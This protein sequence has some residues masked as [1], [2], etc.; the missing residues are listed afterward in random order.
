V[1]EQL[2]TAHTFDPTAS[3]RDLGYT[4]A[5]SIDEGLGRLRESMR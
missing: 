1:V 5:I 4:P 3:K 2:S